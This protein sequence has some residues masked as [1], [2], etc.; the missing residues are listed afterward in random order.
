MRPAQTPGLIA[1]AVRNKN[2]GVEMLRFFECGRVFRHTGGGKGRD[3]ESDTLGFLLSG[4]T[5]PESW[6]S[7]KPAVATWADLVAVI[8]A[9]VHGRKVTVLPARDRD[10]AT[11]GADVAVNGRPIGYMAQVSLA[12]CRELGLNHAVYVAELD[13]RKLQ[14][15]MTAAV[16][17]QELSLF[18]G[19]VRDAALEVPMSVS[20]AA[21]EKAIDSAKEKL[22]VSFRCFDRFEDSTGE[23]MS[24]DRKSLAY[25]FLYR[26]A[27]RTL[28]AQEV[29]DAH[30]RVLAVLSKQI[31][32]LTKR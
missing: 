25:T 20:N 23:K 7:G 11:L 10:N 29:D 32:D 13:V 15:V 30:A 18:P 12:R 31:K 17:A 21:I 24:L 19:S 6:S 16:R 14:E 3:I 28:V 8:E 1:A 2:H 9:L 5:M 4:P 26:A 27:D 22:L